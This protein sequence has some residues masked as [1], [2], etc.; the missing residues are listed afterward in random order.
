LGR[1]Q[2]PPGTPPSS[3]RAPRRPA[4][5]RRTTPL[6]REPAPVPGRLRLLWGHK[7][8]A[9]G[10]WFG[11]KLA[12]ARPSKRVDTARRGLGQAPPQPR[13]DPLAPRRRLYGAEASR[14]ARRRRKSRRLTP[15]AI[16]EHPLG[17]AGRVNRSE[18]GRRRRVRA[19]YLPGADSTGE[20]EVRE[21]KI[22]EKAGAYRLFVYVYDGKGNA[23]TANKPFLVRPDH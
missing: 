20:R 19:P 1:W 18:D 21:I 23:A 15:T 10:T 16:A 9:T 17:G 7:Q 11:M 3:R 14:L 13:A 5:W 8:E 12:T 6:Y 22:P 2:D 4:S